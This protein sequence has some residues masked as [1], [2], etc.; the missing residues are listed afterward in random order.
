MPVLC[1]PATACPSRDASA[2]HAGQM[3]LLQTSRPL[4]CPR[5][6][7]LLSPSQPV[8]ASGG[9]Q[10]DVLALHWLDS[11]LLFFSRNSSLTQKQMFWYV[12]YYWISWK[13]GSA[14]RGLKDRKKRLGNSLGC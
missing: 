13:K 10:R 5:L 14:P 9:E 11:R 4:L 7:L 12:S 8:K 1:P 3:G 2:L 6:E